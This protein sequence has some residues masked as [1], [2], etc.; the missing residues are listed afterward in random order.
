[1]LHFRHSCFL[2][3]RRMSTGISRKE[4]LRLYNS[5]LPSCH[6]LRTTPLDLLWLKL[7][8]KNNIPT[9]TVSNFS[10]LNLKPNFS[11]AMCVCMCVHSSATLL[12]GVFSFGLH[13]ECFQGRTQ[14]KVFA[15]EPCCTSV[16]LAVI[17]SF[18]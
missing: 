6:L 14:L 2:V 17:A 18:K 3:E 12:G 5:D 13:F 16:H 8:H 7:Y 11:R 1:M 4:F 9:K 15:T 10:I